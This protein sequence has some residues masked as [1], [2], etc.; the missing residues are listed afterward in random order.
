MRTAEESTSE[1]RL[2]Q[3]SICAQSVLV[4][5]KIGSLLLHFVFTLKSS[6]KHN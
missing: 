6:L 1:V 4:L 3:V 5:R 2:K